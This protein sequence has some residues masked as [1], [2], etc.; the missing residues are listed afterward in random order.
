[1]RGMP[2]NAGV[3]RVALYNE[4]ND[5]LSEKPAFGG[6]ASIQ[7]HESVFDFHNVPFGFYAVSVFHDENANEKLDLSI[8]GPTE[9]YGFSNGARGLIG[10]PSFDKA[11]TFFNEPHK[12]YIVEV[13]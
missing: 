2:S 8:F 1:M 3:M 6:T 9:R 13:K 4:R 10:P 11:K 12:T 7:H 5:F